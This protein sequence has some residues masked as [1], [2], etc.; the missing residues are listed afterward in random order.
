M[1]KTA[2]AAVIVAALGL[3]AF[4][5]PALKLPFV[6]PKQGQVSK[7]TND[8]SLKGTVTLDGK[9]MPMQQAMKETYTEEIV[10]VDGDAVTKEKITVASAHSK[11]DAMGQKQDADLPIKGNA[12]L[13]SSDGTKT[14]VTTDAGA[15]VDGVVQALISKMVE[16]IG[17]PDKFGKMMA[18]KTFEK[19]KKVTLTADEVAAMMGHQE[20]LTASNVSLTLT[21]QDAKSA[22]FAMD[23]TLEG[24]QNGMTMTIAFKGSIKVDVKAARPL[25]FKMNGTVKGSGEVGGKKLEMNGTMTGHKTITYK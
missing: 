6:P 1:S 16:H 18:E 2:L 25:D 22:T 17:L 14:T 12:Y 3:D 8:E 13:V 15:A 11:V 23:G 10:T 9:T 5:G 19:G 21:G 4:A 24:N 20:G 7:V